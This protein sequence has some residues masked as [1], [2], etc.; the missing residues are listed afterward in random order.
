MINLVNLDLYTPITYVPLH[1]K[2]NAQHKDAEPGIFVGIRNNKARFISC[3]T[4][5]IHL[6]EAEYLV[7]G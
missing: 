3:K 7:E 5:T 4:R 1:A 6:V 2:G